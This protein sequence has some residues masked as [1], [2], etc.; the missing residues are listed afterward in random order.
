VPTC[1]SPTVNQYR[2]DEDEEQLVDADVQDLLISVDEP[3][4]HVTTIETFITYRVVTKTTRSDFDCSE[5]QVH[6]RYQDFL[7]LRSRL[8]ESSPTLIVHPLPE[9]FVVKGLVERF[10][11]DFIETRRR[12]LQRFLARVAQHPL[13]SRSQHL[14]LFLT[15]PVGPPAGAPPA[16]APPADLPHLLCSPPPPPPPSGTAASQETGCG[17]PE[18]DGGDGE[19][20]GRLA[21][22]PEEPA[23]GVHADAPLPGGVR[24]Q[25]Q[26]RGQDQPEDQQRTERVPGG[27]EELEEEVGRL[28]E[29]TG[30]GQQRAEGRLVPLAGQQED[31]PPI[32]LPVGRRREHPVLPEVPGCVGVLPPVSESRASAVEASWSFCL[33]PPPKNGRQTNN[34][35]RPGPAGVASSSFW[36]LSLGVFLF[37]PV[38]TLHPFSSWWVLNL[39]SVSSLT[40]GPT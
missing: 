26:L 14:R 8:E 1:P 10:S 7:W 36:R 9:K 12:A 15:A 23:G 13:L 31:G 33:G 21:P 5:Y 39:R 28:A 19:G 20:R 34:H 2:L 22:G 3:E 40:C 16:G 6:R 30:A 24:Q 17:P 38:R 32:S 11:A 18:Q 27:A 4:S 37:L 25:D 29:R 35:G